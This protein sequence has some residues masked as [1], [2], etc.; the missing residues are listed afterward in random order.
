MA[1]SDEEGAGPSSEPPTKAS[2]LTAV[3]IAAS[4]PA[5]APAAFLAAMP[6]VTPDPD[7][8]DAPASP[9]GPGNDVP[10][11]AAVPL[12]AP[13]Q[14]GAVPAVIAAA[15][16]GPS[17]LMPAIIRPVIMRPVMAATGSAIAPPIIRK[18]ANSTASSS[19]Q[20]SVVVGQAATEPSA[21]HMSAAQAAV[22]RV[23]R[24][25]AESH[26]R[27]QKLKEEQENECVICLDRPMSTVLQP[28]G[29]VQ[30][31]SRCCRE[32]LAIAGSKSVQPQ[33][34]GN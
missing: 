30:M 10:S 33:V 25:I 17:T 3:T 6:T 1:Q 2:R 12:A 9:P 15:V 31:C 16:A 18:I 11:T 24:M 8:M 20:A 26:E 14:A 5:D 13:R 4:P 34:R 7:G 21:P 29:H 32:L 28:C 19:G 27:K 23:R 22:Q